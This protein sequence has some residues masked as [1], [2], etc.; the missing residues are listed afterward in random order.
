MMNDL[1][2]ISMTEDVI[3]VEPKVLSVL[4]VGEVKRGNES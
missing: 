2:I 3:R 1:E 4:S